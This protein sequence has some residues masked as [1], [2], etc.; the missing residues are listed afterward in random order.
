M[1]AQQAY[2]EGKQ[3]GFNAVTYCEVSDSDRR[4][5]GCDCED[6]QECEECISK[7]AFE[8]EERARSYSPFEFIAA[9]INR[10]GAD[11]AEAGSED[12]G[13]EE[14]WGEYDKGVAA[15]IAEGINQRLAKA[16]NAP[17]TDALSDEGRL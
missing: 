14:L 8:S 16:E 4:E 13:S 7:A 9:E 17:A 2:D 1:N 5:A 6:E 3:A 11:D 15:G 10:T 12:E